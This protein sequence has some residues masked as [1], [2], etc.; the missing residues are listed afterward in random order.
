MPE[1]HAFVADEVLAGLS[2]LVRRVL[3][4][5]RLHRTGLGAAQS[6]APRPNATRCR[7]PS[8]GG[9]RTIAA[10]TFDPATYEAFLRTIGYLVTP[11]DAV[12]VTTENVDPE[13]AT[14]AGPQLVVPISNARYALNAA[15]ARWGSLYDALYGTDAISEDGGATRG[16][17]YNKASRRR[18]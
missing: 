4:G 17:G 11:P 8:T 2:G 3:D 7:P 15:N 14:V 1:L 12:S 6:R 5:I 16:G 10:T 9:T 18:A 13:I